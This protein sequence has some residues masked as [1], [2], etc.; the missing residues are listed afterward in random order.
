MIWT[1]WTGCGLRRKK[2]HWSY[3]E[4]KGSKTIWPPHSSRRNPG[5]TSVHV[6]EDSTATTVT[7]TL[8]ISLVATC[9]H[10]RRHNKSKTEN[11]HVIVVKLS[12]F[13]FLSLYIRM[14]TISVVVWYLRGILFFQNLT[15][16]I[17]YR[18]LYLFICNFD[19]YTDEYCNIST[20]DQHCFRSARRSRCNIE[21]PGSLWH[22]EH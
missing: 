8:W 18:K 5:N 16:H 21:S 12:W 19:E 15:V 7:V 22:E 14:M 13:I 4:F 11:M 10:I 9:L 2:R 20:T 1:L 3:C 6:L 17:R